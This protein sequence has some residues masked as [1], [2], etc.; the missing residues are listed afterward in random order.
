LLSAKEF[1]YE[2]GPLSY[3]LGVE[4]VDVDGGVL[5]GEFTISI[6]DVW[7]NT[8]PRDL[9]T[10]AVLE[11]VENAPIGTWIGEFTAIDPDGGSVGYRLLPGYDGYESFGLETNGT[12][13]SAKEFDYEMGPLS[14]Q[15]GVEAV[16]VDGGV[17]T[18]EFTVSI[19]DIWEGSNQSA[20]S[21]TEVLLNANTS[22]HQDS[23]DSE[24]NG[25]T[26]LLTHESS[27]WKESLVLGPF[28]QSDSGWVFSINFGWVYFDE[29]DFDDSWFWVEQLGWV[30]SL[31]STFPFLYL[32][33]YNDWFYFL[34]EDEDK[35]LYNYLLEEWMPL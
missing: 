26:I 29:R 19:L 6:L 3:Q 32:N 21:P 22:T 13:L 27:N 18:G 7:E 4:A 17:L 34:A 23:F 20:T 35:W 15:L 2:M 12:L 24:S 9:N 5:T 16:D 25:S 14:Y 31:E 10:S 11:I 1:D 8:P 28:Y 33:K 30:W